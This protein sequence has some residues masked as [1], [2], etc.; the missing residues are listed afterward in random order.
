MNNFYGTIKILRKHKLKKIEVVSQDHQS[1]KK[2]KR[3]E[4]QKKQ[5]H[6]P[7]LS[8]NNKVGA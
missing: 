2:G 5:I 4:K 7:S 3:S 6:L 8:A 1:G